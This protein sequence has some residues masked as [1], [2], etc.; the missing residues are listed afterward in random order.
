MDEVKIGNP[1]GNGNPDD[2]ASY[3]VDQAWDTYTAEEHETWKLLYERQF[4]I[5]PGRACDEFFQ[6]I[7]AL[8]ID[9]NQI[10]DFKD[11]SKKLKALTGWEVVAV[12]GLIPNLP[13]FKL[14]SERKF[15]AGN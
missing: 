6:G 12:E 14:L 2:W 11:L 8:D 15:P 4:K 3:I 10:P 7:E 5:M 1:T 9:K 13:F